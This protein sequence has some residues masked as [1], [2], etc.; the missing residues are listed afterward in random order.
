MSLPPSSQPQQSAG[1]IA[2][3][4]SSWHSG[5]SP[6]HASIA[7]P[8]AST[9]NPRSHIAD[10]SISTQR[11][12]HAPSSHTASVGAQSISSGQAIGS[13]SA[14]LPAVVAKVGQAQH[15]VEATEQSAS[16][17]QIGGSG[18]RSPSPS[19]SR[20]SGPNPEQPAT[21]TANS[22]DRI[23]GVVTARPVPAPRARNRERRL[24]KVSVSRRRYGES[25]RSPN[26]ATKTDKALENRMMAFAGDAERVEVLAR[27]RTFKASWIE[28]AEAL[29]AVFD[30]RSWERWGFAS[31]E[32]YCKKELHVTP[33]T[34]TKLL[35]SF[36]FLRTSEPQVLER[37]KTRPRET[38]LPSM[39]TVNF[40]ARAAERGAA[41]S[42]TMA[43]IKKAA[44][45]E[46]AGV[47][48]LNRRFGS[49][50]FPVSKA[51]QK[52]RLVRQ[53]NSTGRKLAG[54]I[55]DPASPVP[56][57]VATAVEAA[58]GRLLEFLD[59]QQEAGDKPN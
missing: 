41:D 7:Q 17:T 22:A 4:P 29:A 54:L 3:S 48:T 55:A 15:E 9:S 42:D 31:F 58:I 37:V 32:E 21:R 2:Q 30:K 18:T 27:A 38:T 20:A 36:R 40:V 28:L 24:R 11:S 44:F 49:V 46:G 19:P 43:E 34:A 25:M 39:R 53:L 14:L 6:A 23:A 35:G 1:A 59:Q 33:A 13:Q 10:G 45:E 5:S 26:T 51:D 57:E 12:R 16:I 50:A 52:Q 47:P 56:V 8:A